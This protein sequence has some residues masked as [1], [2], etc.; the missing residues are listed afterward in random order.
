MTMLIKETSS[1]IFSDDANYGSPRW[2][3][4]GLEAGL[5]PSNKESTNEDNVN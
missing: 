5:S 4:L 3:P 1:A 2:T